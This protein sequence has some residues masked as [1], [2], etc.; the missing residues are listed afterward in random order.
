VE[1]TMDEKAEEEY[2]VLERDFM[3]SVGLAEEARA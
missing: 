2:K 1:L 3:V